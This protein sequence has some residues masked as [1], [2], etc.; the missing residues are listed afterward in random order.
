MT[1]SPDAPALAQ[2]R[3][4][5]TRWYLA[6]LGAV[7]L[8]LGGGLFL[9]I[10]QQFQRELDASLQ[11]ATR[12]IERAAAIRQR[13]ASAPVPVVDALDELRIP[14]RRLFL[15]DATGK[16]IRPAEVPSWVRD[17]ART[18]AR[19]GTADV[20]VELPAEETVR[21]HGERFTLRDGT[22]QVAV[23][24]ADE[25]ELE[26]QY[27]TLIT[28]FGAAAL[29]ALV[30]V[31]A[32]SAFLVRQSIAPVA[33]S[34]AQMRRF[35]A[36]AAH[37]LRT[38]VTVVRTKAEVALQRPRDAEGYAEALRGIEVESRRLSTLV[39]DLLTLARAD[40]GERPA[41]LVPCFLD[42]VTLDACDA[43]RSLATVAGITLAIDDFEEAPVR[44]DPELLRQ[45]VLILLDN[46]I[47]YSPAGGT[48]H[49]AVGR[50]GDLARLTVRDHGPGIAPADHARVF[51]RFYRGE[52]ARGPRGETAPGAGL[53]LA[54]AQWIARVHAGRLALEDAPGGGTLAVLQLPPPSGHPT[55]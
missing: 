29:V 54:I 42:D 35:M 26:A 8:V 41:Q 50:T 32:A 36:D 51:D 40:A 49:V 37:E 52:H 17:A 22:V 34:M 43:A 6:T 14:G 30:L 53:G 27:A 39:G 4:R 9:A 16:P 5:L 11:G 3:R 18:A 55:A 33:R 12:E 15:F 31:W 45:A 1:D 13:E 24:V 44:G 48:V 2:V 38:P 20:T 28:A 21:L 25:I 7:L 46:A 10:R 23:A 19:T 47:K